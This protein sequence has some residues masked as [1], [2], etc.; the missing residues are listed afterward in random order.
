MAVLDRRCHFSM[1]HMDNIW[2]TVESHADELH[3]KR[4]RIRDER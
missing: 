4:E 2:D 1:C 3:K